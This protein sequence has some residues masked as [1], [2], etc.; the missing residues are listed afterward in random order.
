[1][2]LHYQ[3]IIQVAALLESRLEFLADEVTDLIT[4]VLTLG[5]DG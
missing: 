3:T 4:R 2:G 5:E 1:M